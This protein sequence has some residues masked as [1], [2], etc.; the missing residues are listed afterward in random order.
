MFTCFLGTV[1]RQL[2]GFQDRKARGTWSYLLWSNTRR[3]RL[4]SSLVRYLHHMVKN[5]G[6]SR[7]YWRNSFF[8][9]V[10]T[11]LDRSPN[12]RPRDI[13]LKSRR[14]S[15]PFLIHGSPPEVRDTAAPKSRKRA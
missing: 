1:V 11:K 3:H 14:E 12:G 9:K 15:P 13:K 6:R 10:I 5:R 8:L 7:F 2:S 4:I